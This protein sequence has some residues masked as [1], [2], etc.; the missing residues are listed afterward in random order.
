MPRDWIEEEGAF[1]F[2]MSTWEGLQYTNCNCN[3]YVEGEGSVWEF[4]IPPSKVY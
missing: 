4:I 3:C 2:S 1:C